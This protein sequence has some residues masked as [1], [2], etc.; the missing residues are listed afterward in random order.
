[1]AT[2]NIQLV[3]RFFDEMCNN[4]Q[5]AL[6]DQLFSGSHTYSD[7]ASPWVGKGP[8]GMKELIGVYHRGVND[9]RWDIHSM[10]ESGDT[11]ITR[12]TGRGTHTGELLGIPPTQK[13][14]SVDGIWMHRIAGGKIVES[15]NCW[16]TLGMLQQLGVVPQLGAKAA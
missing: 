16:D 11:V 1:M 6:A 14:V 10:L 9:A 8:A 13:K 15:W 7:P 12:W 5:L 4:R 3:R 2:E